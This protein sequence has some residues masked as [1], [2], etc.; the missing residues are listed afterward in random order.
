MDIR[1]G[2][3]Q[4]TG[5]LGRHLLRELGRRRPGVINVR[6]LTLRQTAEILGRDDRAAVPRPAF[7]ETF[8]DLVLADP[9][10]AD[11]ELEAFLLDKALYELK[12]ELNNR[13]SW[14]G[15]PV[16]GLLQLLRPPSGPAR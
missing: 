8:A 16:T 2:Y 13:P 9:P 6:C 15:I 12:Y 1:Q 5:D 10:Y 3:L 7:P 11:P 14:V 4:G